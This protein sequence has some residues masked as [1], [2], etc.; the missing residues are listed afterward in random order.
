MVRSLPVC[1][2]RCWT[3]KEAFPSTSTT[4]RSQPG[5]RLARLPRACSQRRG[6]PE[7]RFC[8][9]PRHEGRSYR[10]AEVWCP[11]PSSELSPP[12]VLALTY[13][14]N[15]GVNTGFAVY[16]VADACAYPETCVIG[17]RLVPPSWRGRFL[18][19]MTMCVFSHLPQRCC[20]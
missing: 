11:E 6:V 14:K 4:A 17:S 12:A 13:P 8:P 16:E 19:S 7:Y 10:S 3:K 2:P 15:G 20:G 9:R 1:W 5:P 18:L